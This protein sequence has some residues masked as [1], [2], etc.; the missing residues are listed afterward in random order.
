MPL[1][2]EAFFITAKELL[3]KLRNKLQ[4]MNLKRTYLFLRSAH[5]SSNRFSVS[6]IHLIFGRDAF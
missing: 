1:I 5:H 2:S 6:H 3:K 4:T